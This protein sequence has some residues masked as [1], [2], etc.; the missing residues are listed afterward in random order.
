VSSEWIAVSIAAVVA[1]AGLYGFFRKHD[2]ATGQDSQRLSSVERDNVKHF[3]HAGNQDMHWTKRER[4]ALT[5]T[6]EKI[7]QNVET[8]LRNGKK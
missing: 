4:E 3:A 2:E 8:I 6:L 1:C 7:S 5:K